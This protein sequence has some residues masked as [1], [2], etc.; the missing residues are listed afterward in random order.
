MYCYT[1]LSVLIYTQLS[2]RVCSGRNC[3]YTGLELRL[4]DPTGRVTR[5][6]TIALVPAEVGLTGTPLKNWGTS[7]K[8]AVISLDQAAGGKKK[9]GKGSGSDKWRTVE[10]VNARPNSVAKTVYIADAYI[11]DGD[12]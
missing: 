9:K 12:A 8:Q 11:T 1:Q 7:F 2:V 3:I 10:L 6:E 5:T 4:Q